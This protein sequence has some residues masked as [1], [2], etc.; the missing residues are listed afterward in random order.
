MHVE[1]GDFHKIIN[2]ENY[3]FGGTVLNEACVDVL[4]SGEKTEVDRSQL[5]AI[6][7][8]IARDEPKHIGF[9]KFFL[10][11]VLFILP[12]PLYLL[13]VKIG[14]FDS[15]VFFHRYFGSIVG[16]CY[17]ILAVYIAY[18][19]IIGIKKSRQYIE[20]HMEEIRK[21]GVTAFRHKIEHVYFLETE[22]LSD[23]CGYICYSFGGIFVSDSQCV[24]SWSGNRAAEKIIAEEEKKSYYADENQ[25]ITVAIVRMKNRDYAYL[26]RNS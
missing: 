26:V 12:I 10:G 2:R 6:K 9:G 7:R 17:L 20:E 22:N 19:T 8:E 21:N 16:V 18:C 13:S 25:N 5:D 15:V 1:Y 3:Q 11:V 23:L 24:R 4:F 14:G